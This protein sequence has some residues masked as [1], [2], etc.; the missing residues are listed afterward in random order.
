MQIDGH[1]RTVFDVSAFCEAFL[2]TCAYYMNIT[3]CAYNVKLHDMKL[4][5]IKT[6]K[7]LLVALA[8]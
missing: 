4:S 5:S 2:R 8:S 3:K 1:K 7:D 6:L